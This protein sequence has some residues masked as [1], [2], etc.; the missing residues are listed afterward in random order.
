MATY[1]CKSCQFKTN[2]KSNFQR[3]LNTIKHCNNVKAYPVSNE[4][5]NDE[6]DETMHLLH[7]MLH[8]LH[9]EQKN[10]QNEKFMKHS[11]I[12]CPK[13]HQIFTRPSS[14]KRHLLDKKCFPKKICEKIKKIS[15]NL[16]NYD[17]NLENQEEINENMESTETIIN[18]EKIT[19]LQEENR[20][21]E[22]KLKAQEL[23]LKNRELEL[24]KEKYEAIL[25]EKEKAIHH[26]QINQYAHQIDNSKT[27]N[28][29][30]FHLPDMIT[31]DDFITNLQTTH[32]LTPV[33]TKLLLTT[34]QACGI[35]SYSSC[36]SKTL[37][38]NCYQQL[39]STIADSSNSLSLT[40]AI[41][42][43]KLMPFVSSDSNHRPLEK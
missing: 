20:Q 25:K 29:L 36:L 21:M 40:P 11:N 37:K 31:V 33:Q 15:T 43:A 6:N 12:I 9:P 13:C 35:N 30:N 24:T 22:L 7:P 16:N 26:T 8:P 41:H 18:N 5:D 28:Y 42:Q 34:F 4:V 38:D 10:D 3:H 27:V 32:K 39:M 17:H 23:Q 2:R 1:Y 19:Q 14:L